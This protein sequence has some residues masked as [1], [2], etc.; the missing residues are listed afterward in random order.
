MQK[1][2]ELCNTKGE[3]ERQELLNFLLKGHQ[4]ACHGLSDRP[5]K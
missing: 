4:D 1:E 2:I 3:R 5:V